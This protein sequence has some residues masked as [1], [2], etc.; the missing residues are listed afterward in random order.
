MAVKMRVSPRVAKIGVSF[1]TVNINVSE[2][3]LVYPSGALYDGDYVVDPSANS[4]QILKT[5]QKFMNQDVKINK[6]PYAEV[7]NNSGGITVTIGKEV[8]IYG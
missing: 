1:P 3:R 6:I 7:S 4:A 2:G 5:A 8:E